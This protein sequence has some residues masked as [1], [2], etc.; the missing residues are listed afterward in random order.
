MSKM[1]DANEL[2]AEDFEKSLSLQQPLTVANA[3]TGPTP[4][5]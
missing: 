2:L 3:W 4:P 1:A 5:L